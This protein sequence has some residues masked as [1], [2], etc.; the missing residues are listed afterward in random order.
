M[1]RAFKAGAENKRTLLL[2]ERTRAFF[3][4]AKE[5]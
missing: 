4:H 1:A 3:D 5:N 2:E